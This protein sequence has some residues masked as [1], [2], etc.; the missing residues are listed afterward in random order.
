METKNN[1]HADLRECLA[2]EFHFLAVTFHHADLTGQEVNANILPGLRK[3]STENE[4]ELQQRLGL[5]DPRGEDLVYKYLGP[6][7]NTP[8]RLI[9]LRRTMGLTP[10]SAPNYT[11]ESEPDYVQGQLYF[12]D[13]AGVEGT[14]LLDIIDNPAHWETLTDILM[15]IVYA[16][17]CTGCCDNLR[18]IYIN[19]YGLYFKANIES[20]YHS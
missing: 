19:K 18:G 15:A 6:H 7:V 2:Q 3:C 1:H 17:D 4:T 9:Y 10:G 16:Y 14:T 8:L 12:K 13:L 11:C 20:A 5:G